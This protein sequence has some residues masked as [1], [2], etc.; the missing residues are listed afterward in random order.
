MYLFRRFVNE[1]KI[2]VRI[3]ENKKRPVKKGGFQKRLEEMAKQ[4]GAYPRK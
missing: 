4:R 3:E 1:K 2:H